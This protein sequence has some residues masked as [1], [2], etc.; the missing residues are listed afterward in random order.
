MPCAHG[1]TYL[2]HMCT[3][4]IVAVESSKTSSFHF[5]LIINTTQSFAW[6]ED[7]R[8]MLTGALCQTHQCQKDTPVD[9]AEIFSPV[10]CCGFFLGTVQEHTSNDFP[11][12]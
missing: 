1:I 3:K 6:H 11:V 10:F 4:V 12:M 7:I 5:P 2:I 8:S 9:I